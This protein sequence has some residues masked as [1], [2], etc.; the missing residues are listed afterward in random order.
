MPPKLNINSRNNT[1]GTNGILDL[2]DSKVDQ[3]ILTTSDV[4]FNELTIVTDAEINGN[5]II[6]GDLTVTGAQ[7][8]ISTNVIDLQDNIILI[9]S[10]E[11]GSGVTA[12]YSGLEIDRGS[13]TNYKI[14][15]E[16]STGLFKIGIAGNI[17]A[18]ATR[19]DNP[20]NYGV[21]IYNPVESRMDSVQ[22]ISLPITFSSGVSS[23][24]K[25][26][27][28]V[29][30]NGGVG[31]TEDIS[32]GNRI[33]FFGSNYSSWISSNATNDIISNSGN[34]FIFQ[35]PS[36][37][38]I[39]IPDNVSMIFGNSLSQNIVSDS[40]DLSI[41]N[42]V[43][44]IVL[45][46]SNNGALTLPVNTYL[47]WDNNNN[48]RYNG[49]DI[50]LNS[51]GYF[52]INALLTFSNT[53]ASTS[54]TVGSV[55]LLGGISINNNT[56]SVS[57]SNGGTVTT[58]G[59]MSVGKSMFIG[60]TLSIG[61]IPISKL[62]V[63]GNGV[64]FRSI[65]RNLTTV[66]SN[67]TT[68]NSFE[69][70]NIV[71]TANISNAHTLYIDSPPTVSGG[72]SITNTYSLY[73]NSGKSLFNGIM[74]NT[75]S[76]SSSGVSS[77]SMVMNGGMAIN[78]STNSVN[79]NNG[80]T[81]TSG[82]GGSFLKDFYI[83]GKLNIGSVDETISQSSNKGVVFRSIDKTITTV[84]N[85]DIAFNSFDGGNVITSSAIL[86][87]STVF[88]AGSPSISG[89]GSLANS[90]SLWVNS[91]I[92]RFDDTVTLTKTTASTTSSIGSLLLNGSIAINN[93][94]DSVDYLNGGTFTTAGGL[95]V[96]KSINIGNSISTN[97]G[98]SEHYTLKT[99]NINRFSFGFNGS[100]S[101]GNTGSN[102]FIKR[103]S[104][105]GVFIDTPLSINRE[106]GVINFT[107][108][109]SS[110]SSSSGA[111]V[112]QGGVSINCSTN[113]SSITNG[114]S[115]TTSGGAAI[116]KDLYIGG[117]THITGSNTV[118]GASILSQTSVNTTN[119]IF[120][121]SGAYGASI[122]TTNS[123]I[124]KSLSGS[125]TIDSIASSLLLNGEAGFNI[126]SVGSSSMTVSTGSLNISS[127]G[128]II[129]AGTGA[130]SIETDLGFS[131][132]SGTGGIS[133]NTSDNTYGIKIGTTSSGIPI[134]LGTSTSEIDITG[135]LT[136]RGNMAVLGDTTTINT[137]LITVEDIAIVVNNAPTG[138][139]D[140]GFLIHRWQTPNNSATGELINSTP[141]ET[142]TF[143]SGSSGN[144]LKL[145][146][147]ASADDNH[148]KGWW[149]S[150]I[151][152]TGV[153]QVRRIKSYIGTT[154]MA[155][156]YGTS[157][158]IPV[159]PG[160]LFE[161]GLDIVTLPSSGDS[162]ALFDSPYIGMYFS[163]S[164]GEMRITGVPFDPVSG[165]FNS[166]TSYYNLHVGSLVTEYG[167]V[168]SGTTNISGQLYN[169]VSDTDAFY[170]ATASGNKVFS[171]D[172]INGLVKITNPI[173]TLGSTSSIKLLQKNSIGGSQEYS[174]IE[175][176]ILN[177][178]PG[179]TFGKLGFSTE[180][181]TTGMTEMLNIDG[182]T[183]AVNFTTSASNVNILNT[184]TTALNISGGMIITNT[185]DASDVSTG[186]NMVTA[187]GARISKKLFVGDLL[188]ISGTNK[189]SNVSNTVDSSSSNINTNGDISLYN[190][191]SQTIYF[192]SS[193]SGVPTLTTRS[194]GTKI[195]LKPTIS[196][197]LVDFSLGVSS[198][199]MWYS[200]SDSSSF[201]KFFNGIT[202][203]IRIGSTGITS[204]QAGSGF[205]LYNGGNTSS[206]YENS[207]ITRF[208]PFTGSSS[209]GFVFRDN[210]DTFDRIGINSDG[211]LSLAISAHSGT[212]SLTGS[213]LDIQGTVFTDTFT[214][215]TG[216]A[217]DMVFSSLNQ[218][219]LSALANSVNTT[220]AIN[221]YIGGP[222]KQGTNQSITNS[223]SLF[224][225]I[226]DSVS[227]SLA[228]EN[229]Y[230]LYIE[231]APIGS[232][233]NKYSLYINSGISQ[234]NGKLL[235]PGVSSITSTNSF[236]GNEGNVNTNGD[237][238]LYNSTKQTIYFAP[239]GTGVPTVTSRSS[240]TKIVLL[241]SIS[242]STVDSA[243]GV[244]SSG[245][246]SSVLDTTKSHS[247]Y[248]G[249]SKRMEITNSGLLLETSGADVV[250]TIGLTDNT[251][252]LVLSGG[253]TD[254]G[255]ITLYGNTYSGNTGN[256]N[257][258]TGTSGNI[259]FNTSLS[260]SLTISNSGLVKIANVTDSSGSNTG[261]IS[262][263]G[264]M[265]VEK[266]LFVGSSLVL[267]F[268][269][270]YTYS[271]NSSGNLDIIS[272]VSGIASKHRYFT[273]DG[274]S[275]DNN[276]IEIFA[277][278]T[279]G[280]QTNSNKLSIGYSS[281][282]FSINTLATGTE[283]TKP[284]LLETGANTGQLKLETDGSVSLS[285]A[286]H[287]T[288]A[289]AGSLKL[290]GGISINDT[291]NSSS[292]T[293]GG[294]F[295]TSG[296][297]SIGKDIYIGGDLHVSGSTT[298]G[299]STPSITF[300]NSSNVSGS[301]TSI[302]P[303]LITNGNEI[304][305]STVFRL[306]PTVINNVT[307]FYFSVPSA[308]TN[309]SNI[310]DMVI[311]ANGFRD[312]TTPQNIENI[313]G[314]AITG[315]TNAKISFTSGSTDIHSV[316]I[317]CRYTV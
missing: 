115:L 218:P 290:S 315:G 200:T 5:T 252:G 284:L 231:G 1:L 226:G 192:A 61:D 235:L 57:S 29:I 237:L 131:L 278:G 282:N 41:N 163:A 297:V 165:Q 148:Y 197:S 305:F 298:M 253:S 28:S 117:N 79:V 229:A 9:N 196:S 85:N 260:N 230:S 107:N 170:T 89:G 246:W 87:G 47:K 52:S 255:K 11:L 267:N 2:I 262:T 75:D 187:G 276:T 181:Y 31:I 142:G 247:F 54:T 211:Q 56:D 171:V 81:L 190:S 285:A 45:T 175:S 159:S 174:R 177:N 112:L 202:E 18:I 150:I 273:L 216:I 51:S 256:V 90:F 283:T 72:G 151:S 217:V 70:G 294:S 80:G 42:T 261:S 251:K 314:Y 145:N 120:D 224:I 34:N 281:S 114:G 277:Y 291:T 312:D 205:H 94:T 195:V 164:S 292:V 242:G 103:Y 161:D 143:Q 293:N 144:I 84:S 193:G 227:S 133:L 178:I 153:N 33:K 183:R 108:S 126:T 271:G 214:T 71:T 128:L 136:I 40:A 275:T 304:T 50:V 65:S 296:G 39:Q 179:N 306:S 203:N 27:G 301:I 219:T 37:S 241:P 23:V 154:K 232:I 162:Y 101:G 254:S 16:E 63:N 243:L 109:N 204:M 288:S 53:T 215:D 167:L 74:Y 287:S 121:V 64:N 280:N 132:N 160:P 270:A 116:N 189:I 265:S 139:S 244:S 111:L 17:Q 257:I 98:V 36:L 110:S 213:V 191:S 250:S 263:M 100:E 66:S 97:N 295:T 209:E 138:I 105:L 106:T 248:L 210:T 199:S 228:V 76:T 317:I 316:M 102:L 309:F 25:T 238:V 207:N 113:S 92:A 78:N 279:S 147:S 22:N 289:T 118:T 12:G 49:S 266:T 129:N 158:N 77:A 300:S 135:N 146:S 198:D 127:N 259:S 182:E 184:G 149:V 7:T 249:S 152:G 62:Q 188:T 20:L 173:S 234:L 185:T 125:I 35:Q 14:V 21:L 274:D 91:G 43:G 222:P 46:T 82:G 223:H 186:G 208:K 272:G 60:N 311:T 83:G 245:M 240:G 67:N 122:I 313:I 201:H 141:K 212:P 6:H 59:G 86:N 225:G 180:S 13:L 58:G 123:G 134:T 264:G 310:Y 307:S 157:D 4:V 233:T 140:G 24:S 155:T 96:G 48:I 73:V 156:I 220:N 124:F 15:F 299:I 303:K 68:F 104:D 269:Q 236:T 302:N 88:I 308:I 30:I 26:T 166:P 168:I 95:A 44:N 8:I 169:T 176:T 172:T 286:I 3:A 69:G 10:G 38:S 93:T 32:L 239:N 137:S 99:N 119:G 268:N 194:L 221:T 19:E 55:T 258:A 206:I 130:T